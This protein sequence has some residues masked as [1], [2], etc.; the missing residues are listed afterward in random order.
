M[1]PCSISLGKKFIPENDVI[2]DAHKVMCER[3]LKKI[4]D[5]GTLGDIGTGSIKAKNREIA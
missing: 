3:N 4:G 2:R 5:I 1:S